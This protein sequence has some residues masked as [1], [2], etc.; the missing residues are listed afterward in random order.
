MAAED[1]ALAIGAY[2]SAFCAD[3]VASYIFE[4]TETCFLR[5]KHRGSYQD[6]R[7]LPAIHNGGM[8]TN[9]TKQQQVKQQQQQQQQ[10]Q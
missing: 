7:Q 9:R 8:A 1:I 4:M 3:I 5:A 6:N 10:Q 2:E